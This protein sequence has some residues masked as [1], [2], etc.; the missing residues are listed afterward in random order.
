MPTLDEAAAAIDDLNDRIETVFKNHGWSEGIGL[1]SLQGYLPT[2]SFS[3]ITDYI[4]YTSSRIR[5]LTEHDLH[6]GRLSTFVGSIPTLVGSLAVQQMAN[7]PST[8]ISGLMM[9]LHMINA[10]LPAEPKGPVKL[11]WESVEDKNYF[12]RD[13][14][15]RLRAVVNRL[16]DLEPRSDEIDRKISDIEAAHETAERLPEDLAELAAKR[17]EVSKIVA[18]VDGILDHAVKISSHIEATSDDAVEARQRM[19]T[20]EEQAKKLI[21]RSEQALRGSTGVGLANAFEKRKQGLTWAGAFWVAGL[22]AALIAAFFIGSDRVKALQ[23]ALTNESSPQLVWMNVILTIFGI[24]GPIWFAWLSTKQI[25]VNFKLAE[26]Y[27]FKAAVSKAYEGYRAEA[28]VI[29]PALQGRLFASA[30]DRLEEAPIRLMDKENH[31]SPLQ[32]LLANPA[33]RK[34]LEGIPG[35]ADKII[36]LIPEKG[37]MAAVVGST[38]A[39]AAAVAAEPAAASP[40]GSGQKGRGRVAG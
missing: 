32:E 27:A 24:G 34:S 10:R 26:D 15:R 21:E 36:A 12:P 9:T 11:D 33:I 7:D 18:R 4:A 19:R 40:E 35:I 2:Y 20:S 3:F 23:A 38:A 22:V 39:V 25:A 37:G 30:L 5:A 8:T 13:I 6:T 28:V 1:N 31:S 17:D 29:D 16:E 14:A